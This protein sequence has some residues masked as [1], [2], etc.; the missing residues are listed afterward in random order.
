[1]TALFLAALLLAAPPD[2]ATEVRAA[3]ERCDVP[4]LRREQARLELEAYLRRHE[5]EE[6]YRVAVELGWVR[7]AIRWCG[8]AT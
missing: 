3:E 4:A 6:A 2:H 1:M 5:P 8:R 7:S